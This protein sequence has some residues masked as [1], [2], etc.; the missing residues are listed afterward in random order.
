MATIEIGLKIIEQGS[1]FFGVSV[2]MSGQVYSLSF[3]WNYRS[4]AWYL[5]IND[6]VS[7]LKIVNG[8]DLLEPYHYIDELPPGK[9]GVVRNSGTKSKPGF[10]NFGIGKE[11]TLVYEEPNDPILVA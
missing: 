2:R 8:I 4:Q 3:E 10:S 5:K 9:L 11:M 7:G 6:L 1:P